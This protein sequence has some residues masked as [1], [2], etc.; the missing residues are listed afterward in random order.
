[1][2]VSLYFGL[3]GCGKSSLCT[4]FAVDESYKIKMGQSPYTCIITNIPIKCEHVYYCD[5]FSWLGTHYVK[6]ALY[7]IDEATLQFDSR[8]YKIF[9][10]GLVKGFVLH[11]HTQND[12]KV[13]VQ[14]WNRVDKTIRDICDKVYYLH[15]GAL[16]KSVTYINHI[17]YSIMFPDS[18]DNYGDIVMGYKKCSL[19]SRMFST[20]LYR[21]FY[22][23]YFDSF[24]IPDDMK[25][26]PPGK[27]QPLWLSPSSPPP[28]SSSSSSSFHSSL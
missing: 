17:P 3:P 25:P 7:L 9:A 19:I 15:K 11:R 21:K 5:E 2:S 20:R 26:L 22:Y 23:P 12:I 1:M 4:S 10:R 14:I 18:G 27:L 16:F 24:W 6:G 8:D 28:P 13:F